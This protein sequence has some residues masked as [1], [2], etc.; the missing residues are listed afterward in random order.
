M[1]RQEQRMEHGL[2]TLVA[3]PPFDPADAPDEAAIL[4]GGRELR[5]SWGA[6]RTTLQ[7]SVLRLKCRCAWCTRARIDGRFPENFDGVALTGAEPLGGYAVHLTFSD[8]HDRGIYPW[9]YLRTL[10]PETA[11]S[12]EPAQAA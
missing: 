3:P 12:S 5:L 6:R 10:A 2:A 8:G 11:P 9:T 4:G 7:A 1:K